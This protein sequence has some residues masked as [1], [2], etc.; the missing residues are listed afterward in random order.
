MSGLDASMGFFFT[1]FS[2][3]GRMKGGTRGF[4]RVLD[5]F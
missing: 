4:E 1:I 5:S 3:F 2:G